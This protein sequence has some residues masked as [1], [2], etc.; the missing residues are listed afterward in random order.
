MELDRLTGLVQY[1]DE[2]RRK[3]RF[4]LAQLQ[5]RVDSLAREVEVRNRIIQSTETAL[6]ELRVQLTRAAGWTSAIEQ[7]RTELLQVLERKEEQRAKSE[8]EMNRNRQIEFESLTRQI[9]ELKREVKTYARYADE[10]DARRSEDARLNENLSRLQAQVLEIE[11]RQDIPV[12]QISYLEEQRRQDAKRIA[13]LEQEFLSLKRQIEAL[14]PRLLLLDEAVRRKHTEI[15]EAVRA[16]EAQNELLEKQRLS[17]VQQE[18]QIIEYREILEKLKERADEIAQQVTGYFQMREEVKREI[19]QLKDFEERIEARIK[20]L[21][22]LQR[23]AETRAWRSYE[24]FQAKVEKSFGDFT[25]QQNEMWHERD[26]RISRYEQNLLSLEEE[27]PRFQPQLSAI[28]D[29]LE[30]F[31]KLLFSFSREWLGEAEEKLE[32]AK[33]YIGTEVKLSRRQRRKMQAKSESKGEQNAANSD[34]SDSSDSVD[35]VS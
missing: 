29:V 31:S 12:T 28:Y 33:R 11:R 5:E 27:M 19:S 15:E 26:K 13:A 14:P 3:D 4:L 25:I 6:N 10:L 17:A 7:L 20:E 21:F 2:E 34:V 30:S 24:A 16:L 1:L 23:D 32:Q 8:G 35:L 9:A 18:R 22:E